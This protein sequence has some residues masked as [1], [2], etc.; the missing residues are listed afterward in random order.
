[1]GAARVATGARC[2]SYL[3][4]CRRRP[5]PAD[6][7][8]CRTVD[9]PAR[10]HPARRPAPRPARALLRAA[11][12]CSGSSPTTGPRGSAT[13]VIVISEFVRERVDRPARARPGARPRGLARASTTSASRPRRTSR[14]SRCC[15]I[16]PGPGRTRTT[17]GCSRRSRELRARA[18]GAPAR[19]HGR[20]PR[21][22]R[23]CR[24][25]VEARARP[26]ATS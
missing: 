21:R 3:A 24:T 15:S 4:R 22:A 17:R 9:R 26:G 11:S 1:M 23:R 19:P 25:G 8:A 12:G 10:G 6:R 7:S 2:G 16:P 14:A 18:P 13:E 20:R 5:L